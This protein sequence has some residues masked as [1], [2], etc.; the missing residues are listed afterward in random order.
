MSINAQPNRSMETRFSK[1][2]AAK[3]ATKTIPI[4]ACEDCIPAIRASRFTVG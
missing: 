4:T 2:R 1:V 3:E